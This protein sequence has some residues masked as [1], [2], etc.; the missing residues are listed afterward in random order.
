M[1]Y[2]R[3]WIEGFAH[4]ARPLTNLQKKDVTFVWDDKCK[5]A[6]QTLKHRV[7]SDPV[8]WQPDHNRPFILEV[9]ASQ[10]AT[11]TILWQE[12]N[13]GKKCAIGYDS[14]TLSN[15]ERNYPIYNRELLAM[16]HGLENW[17]YLLAGTKMPIWILSDHKNLTYWK[18]GHNIGQ[19]VARWMGILADY[20]IS[21]EHHPGTTN[22]ANPLSCRPDHD[23]GS[24]DNL[25]WLQG[26][27]SLISIRVLD[28][29]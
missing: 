28:F 4:I 5:I 6:V 22:C 9:D 19:Q 16:I 8:L 21:I 18:D 7:T 10:Y 1:G 27:V 26:A 24:R 11:S 25:L 20:N 15:T 2:H 3:P 12:D 14:S 13:K 23:D 17:R 29:E